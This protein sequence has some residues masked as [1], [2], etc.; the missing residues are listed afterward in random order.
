MWLL[1]S[2][3]CQPNTVNWETFFFQSWQQK[4]PKIQ[5]I[6]VQG[7]TIVVGR[8]SVVDVATGFEDHGGTVSSK[9]GLQTLQKSS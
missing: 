7:P 2:V 6:Y 8:E 5:I 4:F 1:V 9:F 3:Q